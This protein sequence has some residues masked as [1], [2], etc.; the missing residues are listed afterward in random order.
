V[1]P[2]ALLDEAA[3]AGR[4]QIRPLDLDREISRYGAETRGGI[5]ISRPAPV[6]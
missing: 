5:G 6:G 2:A 3:L 4:E 1:V